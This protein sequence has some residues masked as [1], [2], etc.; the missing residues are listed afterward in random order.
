VKRRLLLLAAGAGIAFAGWRTLTPPAIELGGGAAA[1]PTA[2]EPRSL[3]LAQCRRAGRIE[4]LDAFVEDQRARAA[5]GGAAELRFLAEA[6]LERAL[7]RSQHK[8]LRPGEPVFAEL[9][10]ALAQDVDA[11][12]AALAAARRA[13][14]DSADGHRLEAALLSCRITGWASALQWNGAIDAALRAAAARAPEHPRL[15]V[16][17]GCQALFAPALLGRDL[18]RARA[19]LERAAAALPIDE[20]PLVFLALAADLDGRRDDALAA[21]RAAAERNPENRYARVVL[22]RLEA[23]EA[24]P[25]GRDL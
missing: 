11:G 22:A 23:R 12:L 14:D 18:P 3:E 9:P 2:L 15:L 16:A 20:R 7:L 21:L 25:F 24:D 17:L 1:V 10:P 13:G 5:G 4:A 6:L 19:L 8:G